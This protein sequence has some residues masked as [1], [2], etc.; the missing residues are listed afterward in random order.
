MALDAYMTIKGQKQ[1]DISSEAST[2]KSAGAGAKFDKHGNE[3]TVLALV[4]AVVNPRD[5]KSG[6]T[7]GA[8]VHQP[9]T[10]TKL[11]DRSSPLL[12]QALAKG[13][14]LTEISCKLYRP[15]TAG[16]GEPEEFFEY[17]W[18]NAKLCEGKSYLPLTVD[19]SNDHLRPMEDWSFTY[20]KVTWKHTKAST[21]GEDSWQAA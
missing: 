4:G 20:E 18:E 3:I 1:G 21:E 15:D 9:V 14:T 11:T 12:W 8:R 2:I 10:F 5:P 13:E 16:L 6:V 7:S 17:K 19:A